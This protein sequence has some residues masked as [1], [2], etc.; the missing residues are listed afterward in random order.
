MA[1]IQYINRIQ[2]E[3]GARAQLPVEVALLGMERPLIISDR[4]LEANGVLA[5]ALEHLDTT[6]L[7]RFLDVPP[8]PT[9]SAVRQALAK[10]QETD[11]D[12]IIAIGGGS[13]MDCG[14][15]VA[16]MATHEG[17][18]EQYLAKSGGSALIRRDIAPVIAIPTTAGT[19]SEVGR[20]A[21]ITLDNGDKEVFLSPHL[22][23][24]VAICDPELTYGLPPHLTAA[25]G[26]DAFTHAFESYLSPAVNPPADAVALDA[27]SRLWQYLPLAVADGRDSVA[28]WEVMMGATEAAM[29]TW[30]GLGMTHALSMPFDDLG[31]HHGTVVGLLLPHTVYK[32]RE[33]VPETRI[34]KVESTLGIETGTLTEALAAFIRRIG[35]PDGLASLGVQ[36]ASVPGFGVVA[37]RSAFNASAPGDL[38]ASDYEKIALA[39]L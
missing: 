8:N 10:Y 27:L 26:I 35:L 6:G 1:F 23:P 33:T 14:K 21:G 31:L 7:P 25:T 29:T 16:L 17:E 30:K 20:G 37:A 24:R 18:L 3:N 15:A 39:A 5:A 9:A 13:P 12:G 22:I 34:S 11:C 32:L 36:A 28:R 2:F 4:R 38:S 19:G